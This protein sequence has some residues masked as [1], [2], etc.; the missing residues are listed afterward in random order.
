[1]SVRPRRAMSLP[2]RVGFPIGSSPK[3]I[4]PK[5]VLLEKSKVPQAVIPE[6]IKKPDEDVC[7]ITDTS[8]VRAR[9]IMPAGPVPLKAP[10][11]A[12]FHPGSVTYSFGRSPIKFRFT[13]GKSSNLSFEEFKQTHLGPKR[14]V[15]RIECVDLDSDQEGEMITESP[16][17]KRQR[18]GLSR[19]IPISRE[20]KGEEVGIA[21]RAISSVT[22]LEVRPSTTG[23][24]NPQPEK[25]SA[26]TIV[27][28]AAAP[29]SKE[30]TSISSPEMYKKIRNW[31]I[32]YVNDHTGAFSESYW[33][34]CNQ[35]LKEE[36]GIPVHKDFL[37]IMWD[38]I[39]KALA[40]AEARK[41]RQALSISTSKVISPYSAVLSPNSGSHLVKQIESSSIIQPSEVN[42]QQLKRKASRELDMAD[43]ES[44]SFKF[45]KPSPN[46]EESVNVKSERDIREKLFLTLLSSSGISPAPQSPTPD[47]APRP[48]PK[49]IHKKL[50]TFFSQFD[51]PSSIIAIGSELTIDQ[52]HWLV[53]YEL[54]NSPPQTERKPNG[55]WNTTTNLF[56]SR[57]SVNREKKSITETTARLMRHFRED[58]R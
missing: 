37:H 44:R 52:A 28:L 29:S 12:P 39:C 9:P 11:Y 4:T 1:M 48:A 30:S 27:K 16:A 43:E 10:F 14:P 38:Q 20:V 45:T 41:M 40:V 15:R 17:T 33:A 13:P 32:L 36:L 3:N 6:P 24:I 57:F 49:A 56:N 18:V 55:Y 42:A 7:E 31:L 8:I 22:T 50:L 19:S 47:R 23:H 46:H 54:T 25:Y 58:S 51:Y 53:A 5:E 21:N 35:T 34:A 26:N 2:D